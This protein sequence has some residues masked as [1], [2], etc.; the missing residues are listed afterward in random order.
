VLQF[1]FSGGKKWDSVPP[2]PFARTLPTFIYMILL[3]YFSGRRKVPA[4]FAELSGASASCPDKI[5]HSGNTLNQA[6]VPHVQKVERPP[7]VLP[8]GRSAAAPGEGS[9][10]RQSEEPD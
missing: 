10:E 1:V 9:N 7:G 4:I 5:T 2:S 6:G 8:S 3:V